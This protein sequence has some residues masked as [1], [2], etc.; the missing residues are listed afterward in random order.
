MPKSASSKK[1]EQN[2]EDF[3]DRPLSPRFASNNKGTSLEDFHL[4]ANDNGTY[5]RQFLSLTEVLDAKIE[6]KKC[7]KGK[8][9]LVYLHSHSAN[10]IEGLQLIDHLLPDFNLCL[11]DFSG[12]G[13]SEGPYVTLGPKEAEEIR[14]LLECL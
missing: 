7:L 1:E 14:A 6:P 8:P 5:K 11:F 2:S 10:R 4:N 3:I 9:M 13:H 12:C